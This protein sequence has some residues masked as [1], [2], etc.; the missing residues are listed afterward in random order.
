[1]TQKDKR[2]LS[3]VKDLAKPKDVEKEPDPILVVEDNEVLRKLFITQLQVLKLSGEEAA[4]GQEAVEAVKKR[5]YGFILMD[6][7]MPVLD[8]LDATKIIRQFEKENGRKR[9]P[10]IAV[11]GISDRST[12]I[13]SGMDDFMNKPFLLEHLRA[14]A[15][16][17]L[18]QAVNS[19][20]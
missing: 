6:V 14:T 17:W 3:I 2:A 8:G 1:M 9:T 16:R 18:E 5:Q 10:I 15:A 7:S 12:C 13:T 11:T 4:N 20:P 19:E